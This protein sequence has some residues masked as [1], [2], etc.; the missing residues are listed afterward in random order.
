MTRDERVRN[1][2]NTINE[3]YIRTETSNIVYVNVDGH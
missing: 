2:N 3:D 1:I